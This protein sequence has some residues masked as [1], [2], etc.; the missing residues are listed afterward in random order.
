MNLKDA[1][2]TIP[3]FPKPGI[4]FRDITSLLEHPVAFKQAVDE[5]CDRY[6][7]RKIDKIVAL[8]ARGFVFASTMAYILD[9]PLVLFRKKGKLP[10]ET[11]SQ[12]YDLEYGQDELEVHTNS[13]TSGDH[14]L[15]IDDLLATG[16]TMIGAIKLTEA[17]DAHVE[18]TAFIIDLPDLGGREKIEELNTEV[19]TLIEFEGE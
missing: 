14:V 7:D 4:M 9:K 17:L 12:A 6:R 15:I 13:I 3:D 10:G 11:I 8:E 16:G 19:F 2:R 1:I 18:S 5:L